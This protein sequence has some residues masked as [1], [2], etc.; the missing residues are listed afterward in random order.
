MPQDRCPK[1]GEE[2]ALKVGTPDWRECILAALK[3]RKK[4]GA[5]IE[6]LV[7]SVFGEISEKNS[8]HINA[9]NQFEKTIPELIDLGVVVKTGPRYH[10][11]R[12][13]K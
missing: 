1:V 4:A 6:Q 3:A 8:V 2:F 7:E 5:T 13:V 12:F 11:W 9:K 10:W